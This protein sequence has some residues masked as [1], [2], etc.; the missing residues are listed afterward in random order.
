MQ[1]WTRRLDIAQ[2]GELARHA[3]VHLR[4]LNHGLEDARMGKEIA[5]LFGFV[6]AMM[7]TSPAAGFLQVTGGNLL[8]LVTTLYPGKRSR[9][10]GQAPGTLGGPCD[11]LAP[12]EVVIPDVALPMLFHRPATVAPHARVGGRGCRRFGPHHN[13]DV[14]AKRVQKLEQPAERI[15]AGAAVYQ[16]RDM[17]LLNAQN[18]S[19]LG[20]RETAVLDGPVDLQLELRLQLLVISVR[21][22]E[23]SKH[24]AAALRHIRI[25]RF[26]GHQFYLL[27]W[28]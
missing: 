6:L 25:V 1:A 21:K 28:S 22:S 12:C 16:C 9:P 26:L 24:V 5:P 27:L 7:K 15:V 11:G 19:S 17:R 23:V 18:L 3:G 8:I 4:I 20:L 2:I 14:A 13:L 10:L